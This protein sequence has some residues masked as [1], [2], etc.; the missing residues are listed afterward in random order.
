MS[1]DSIMQKLEE[2]MQGLQSHYSRF[3]DD[4][5]RIEIDLFK[6]KLRVFY[7]FI[8]EMERGKATV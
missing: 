2:L 8:S 5:S 6:E 3:A 1:H 7:D 4:P